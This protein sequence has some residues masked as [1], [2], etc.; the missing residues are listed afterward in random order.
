MICS[1]QNESLSASVSDLGAELISVKHRGRERLW[2]NE[3]GSWDGHAPILFPFCGRC[4]MLLHGK[5]YGEGFHGIASKQ[6]FS[7]A[8]QSDTSITLVLTENART[9]ETYPFRFAFYVRYSLIGEVLEITY[10]VENRSDDTMYYAC[11]AHD[12]FAL[13]S[14]ATDYAL[15]FPQTEVFDYQ[16]H[17]GNGRL[18]GKTEP[19]GRGTRLP[20]ENRDASAGDTVILQ[21]LRSRSVRLTE[22]Q[23]GNCLA[24]IRFPD[25]SNLLLWHPKDSRM[26]CIEPWQNLPDRADQTGMFSEKPGVVPLPPAQQATYTRTI[27]YF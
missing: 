23:S 5:D 7:V 1:I 22:A 24:E 15:E 8:E 6:T 12:S 27:R 13:S 19:H 17:D 4:R 18:S 20:L 3:D 14:D 2:Q 21:E 16:L 11:G 26:I 10:R 25:F 9:L